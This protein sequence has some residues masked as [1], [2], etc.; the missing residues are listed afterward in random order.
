MDVAVQK[1][2]QLVQR[3]MAEQGIP[4]AVVCVAVDGEEAWSEGLGHAD[5]ENAVRCSPRTVMR[6]A[7][8]SKSLTAVAV[9]QLWERGLLDLDA[10]VQSYV[11]EFPPKT[12]NGGPVEVTSR[13]LLSH[14]AGIRHYQRAGGG[15]GRA[16]GMLC[17]PLTT[18]MW[19]HTRAGPAERGVPE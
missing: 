4:G 14:L 6:I 3:V 8:I 16:R 7:S 12:F 19:L 18:T 17:S 5:L 11:P 13:Q 2:R 10:A 1:S 15:L 9:M